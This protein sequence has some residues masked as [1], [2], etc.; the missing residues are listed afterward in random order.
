VVRMMRESLRSRLVLGFL[1]VSFSTMVSTS[2]QPRPVTPAL[3]IPRD[4]GGLRSRQTG[5]LGSIFSK[6]EIKRLAVMSLLYAG[7]F[8]YCNTL[9][10]LCN[11]RLLLSP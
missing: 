11:G 5:V 4:F 9:Q 6:S 2:T 7:S 1:V 3:P 8:S 10:E